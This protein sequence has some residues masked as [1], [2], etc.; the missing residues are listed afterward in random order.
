[1]KPAVLRQ[2]SEATVGNAVVVIFRAT[3][4]GDTTVSFGLTRGETMK[5]YES[6][7]YRVWVN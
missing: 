2:V 1:M 7:R 4:R 5:A 6:R 3:G